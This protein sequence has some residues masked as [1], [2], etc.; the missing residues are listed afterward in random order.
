VDPLLAL[1]V[2]AAGV[3]GQTLLGGVTGVGFLRS[4]LAAVLAW[5]VADA[6]LR[7]CRQRFGGV[8]GDTLGAGVEVATTVALVVLSTVDF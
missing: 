6:L 5:A 4:A 7:R 8:T 1:A 3:I 2:V